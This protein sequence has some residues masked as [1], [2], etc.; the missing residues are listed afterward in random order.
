VPIGLCWCVLLST[1]HIQCRICGRTAARCGQWPPLS[2]FQLPTDRTWGPE[3]GTV[4]PPAYWP[5]ILTSDRPQANI[6]ITSSGRACLA[7]LGLSI[8]MENLGATN[9]ET[10]RRQAPE[11]PDQDARP[12]ESQG[13]SHSS[14]GGTLRW[15]APELLRTDICPEN[16]MESDMYA[17]GCVVYE[18]KPFAPGHLP[19]SS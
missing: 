9:G 5:T 8:M 15:Q 4:P 16:T 6:F 12:L 7:D 10:L 11:F 2:S 17:F 18:V 19:K 1:S 14:A 13:A 3:R